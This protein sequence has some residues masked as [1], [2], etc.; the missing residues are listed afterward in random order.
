MGRLVDGLLQLARASEVE[1]L[2]I[3][4]V[5]VEPLL[6]SIASQLSRLGDRDWSVAGDGS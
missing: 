3:V 6:Q 4:P 5:P 2:N 1:R